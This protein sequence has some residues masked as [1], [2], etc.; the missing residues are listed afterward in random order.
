MIEEHTSLEELLNRVSTAY[1]TED[2]SDLKQELELLYKSFG[3][4]EP[5]KNAF[6]DALYTLLCERDR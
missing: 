2:F 4:P 3:D 5:E 1:F 6:K